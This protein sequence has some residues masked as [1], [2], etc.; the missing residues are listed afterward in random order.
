MDKM[1]RVGDILNMP[2]NLKAS[3]WLTAQTLHQVQILSCDVCDFVTWD[4]PDHCAPFWRL[5]WHNNRGAEINLGKGPLAIR[6][7]HLVLIPPNTH[8]ASRLTKPVRQLFLHFLIEP[9]YRAP[10]GEVFQFRATKPQ[11]ACCQKIIGEL[12]AS[13]AGMAASLLSQMLVSS[14]L[15]QLPTSGWTQR[16]EDARIT[17]AVESIAGAYPGKIGNAVLARDACMHP[18]A[19]IRLFRQCTGHTPLEFLMHLR[20]EEACS[21]LHY[22]DASIDEIAEK[23]GWTDR[24]YFT[25]VFSRSMNC[26]PARYRKLVN[27][28]SRLRPGGRPSPGAL[29]SAGRRNRR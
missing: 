15:L 5:Y 24:G 6:P 25:R 8:F 10:E 9:R 27:V 23:T 18:S 19:F 16:F 14:A 26:S 2:S 3:R 1:S 28:S 11:S 17:R 12:V 4:A 20:L 29:P 13:P 7:A 21:M 22:D